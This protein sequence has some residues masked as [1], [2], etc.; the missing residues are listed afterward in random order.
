LDIVAANL[1]GKEM[2]RGLA[3]RAERGFH[4][5][6]GKLGENGFQGDRNGLAADFIPP[7][8]RVQFERQSIEDGLQGQL[9]VGAIVASAVALVVRPRRKIGGWRGRQDG[10]GRRGVLVW[11]R[12]GRQPGQNVFQE[13]EHFSSICFLAAPY[14]NWLS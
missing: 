10:Q 5:A 2:R 11:T 1:L 8:A 7:E 14:S 13:A 3:Q 9:D 12:R 6:A 4:D